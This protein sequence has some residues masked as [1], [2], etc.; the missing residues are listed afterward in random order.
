MM[1]ETSLRLVTMEAE[2]ELQLVADEAPAREA[3][4]FSAAETPPRILQVLQIE[5]PAI[6]LRLMAM[7][8]TV[9]RLLLMGELARE[10]LDFAE[11]MAEKVR[12][13]L[14]MKAPAREALD[15]AAAMETPWLLH[16]LRIEAPAKVP[17][18]GD[19]EDGTAAEALVI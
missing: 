14:M 15:Y 7:A 18:Y 12:R 10:E 11:K 1:V 5:A 6:A 9:Q 4:P 3:L 13:L 17:H 16:I 2:T 19:R 8:P